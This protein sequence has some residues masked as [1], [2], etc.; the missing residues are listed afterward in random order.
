MGA[1]TAWSIKTLAT[2][3]CGDVPIIRPVNYSKGIYDRL[4]KS[5]CLKPDINSSNMAFF[6]CLCKWKSE[7][8]ATI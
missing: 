5:K 1:V 8:M 7:N 2:T 3:I 4:S 6:L